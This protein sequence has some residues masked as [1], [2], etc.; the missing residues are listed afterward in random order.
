MFHAKLRDGAH[1]RF[2]RD[3]WSSLGPL[4][5]AFPRLV[6]LS[7]APEATVQQAWRNAWCPSLPDAMS[8]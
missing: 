7:V 6:G 3:D 5:D 8:D 2:W 4:R 1:F